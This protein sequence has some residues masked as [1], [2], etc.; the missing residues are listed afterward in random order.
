MLIGASS[1]PNTKVRQRE[2]RAM[3]KFSGIIEGGVNPGRAEGGL[4]RESTDRNRALL[5]QGLSSLYHNPRWPRWK[6]EQKEPGNV[7]GRRF[8]VTVSAAKIPALRTNFDPPTARV[9]T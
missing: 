6:S 8:P 4:G 9:A 5:R 2:R 3:V 7:A 1:D